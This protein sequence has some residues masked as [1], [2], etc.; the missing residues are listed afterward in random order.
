[1]NL[2]QKTVA[3]FELPAGKSEMIVFD[4]DLPGFGLRLRHGGARTWIYQFKLGVQHRR[5]TIG[6]A[7][8]L[9][10]AQARKTATE[11]HAMVR[12][13]RDP[14]GEKA[15][16]RARAAET[17]AAALKN[18]LPHQQSRLKPRSYVEIERHLLKHCKP[19]HGLRLGKS[20]RSHRFQPGSWDGPP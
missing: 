8:A 2:T 19:L 18:Y 15:E 14:A 6:N 1:M 20:G 10:A 7:V 16:G 5:I 9:P 4:D 17:V 3:T 11:L 13:G 12:L